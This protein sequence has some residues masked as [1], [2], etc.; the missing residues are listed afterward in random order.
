[1]VAIDIA[2]I[3]RNNNGLTYNL[4]NQHKR[5]CPSSK[6][7]DSKYLQYSIHVHVCLTLDVMYL[8]DDTPDFFILFMS[9][10]NSATIC[11]C[12]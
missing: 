3:K 5:H 6:L 4:F 12:I 8:Y 9:F 10:Q 11:V 1:M 2:Y 7:E